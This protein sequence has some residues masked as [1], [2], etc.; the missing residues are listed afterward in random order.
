VVTTRSLSYTPR[1]PDAGEPSLPTTE[2]VMGRAG[3]ENFP[4]ASWLL[5]PRHRN[6]LRAIYGFARLVDEI[7]D[8][9]DGDRLAALQL[10]RGQTTLALA[11][12]APD[13]VH[14]VVAAAARTVTALGTDAAPLFDLIAANERDQVV[15]DYSSFDELLGYCRL[16][17]N[18]VG[19]LVLALFHVADPDRT[20]WSDAICTGLQL[21]EH[22]QDVA[23]D[24]ARGRV[25]LPAD[26][27]L[28]FDVGPDELTAP[29]PAGRRLRALMAF[30][31]A[32]AR[33]FLDLG[34]PLVGSLRGSARWAVAGYWAGGHA[35]LDAIA[36]ADFDPLRGPPRPSKRRIAARSFA[37]LR[38][39]H[40][41]REGAA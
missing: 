36:R 29:P 26:D 4:V 18:P 22:W 11:D 37:V 30:E 23:E 8:A 39:S 40:A 33:R 20:G 34:A 1:F 5:P 6:N 9:Y 19:R 3:T 13:G 10:L 15:R 41:G 25:Y 31:V 27:L 24:A 7:G 35:A 38:A 28:R 32:R 16:S 21:A 2:D 14:P 12:P 17:A